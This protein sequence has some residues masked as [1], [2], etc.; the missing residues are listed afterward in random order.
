MRIRTLDLFC[1]GGGSSWGAQAAGAEIVCGVDAWDLAVRAYA[2][3]FSTAKA[4]HLR[5]TPESG[6]ADLGDIGEIDLLLGSPECTHHTCARG[7]RPRDEDSK[8]TAFYVTN[9]AR[10]LSPRPRWVVIENVVH[11]RGW[12]GYEPLL[13]ELRRLGY[14]TEVYILDASRFGVPQSR[15]RVFIVG[16]LAAQPPSEVRGQRGRAPWVKGIIAAEDEGHRSRLL[17]SE[18]RAPATLERA[19]RGIA[20]LGEGTPFLIVYYGS[21][22]AGG[23]QPLDRPLRTITTLDRFGLVTWRGSTPMLRMLQVDELMAAMGFWG[24]YNLDG[25]GQRR[26]RIRLLGNGVC[27]PVMA[28]IVGSLTRGAAQTA[29]WAEDEEAPHDSPGPLFLAAAE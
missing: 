8:R 7:S 22:G 4:V 2:S 13:T 28:A 26:D 20:A 29:S 21:D 25:I 6:P 11:M 12:H 3:N 15:R 9:F 16:D 1:G 19:K 10:D 17:R 18:G 14:R 23:W 5:M 27:P 24:G